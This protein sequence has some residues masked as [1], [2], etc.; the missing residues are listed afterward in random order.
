[1]G[2]IYA[3]AAGHGRAQADSGARA[4]AF[5]LVE[6]LVVMG[7][8]ALLLAV[9]LPALNTARIASQIAKAHADLR[10]IAAALAMYRQDN[11]SQLPP[12]RFSCSSRTEYELPVE[13]ALGRYLPAEHKPFG[14]AVNMR[15]VFRPEETYRYRAPGPAIMNESTLVPDA[16]TIWVPDGF[17][18]HVDGSTGRYYSNPRTSPVRYA[19]WSIGP[20]RASPGFADSPG[21]APVPRRYWCRGAGDTGVITHFEDCRGRM[22][23]S[24]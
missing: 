21:R 13:L 4:A 1:M 8:I 9:L 12:T 19:L 3:N 6:L 16:S 18:P 2:G 11:R 17:P 15:D 24:P 5:S 10:S 22:Y 7:I 23:M 20:S 14:V